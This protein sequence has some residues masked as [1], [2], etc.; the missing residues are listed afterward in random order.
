MT[1]DP[2]AGV[3][4]ALTI[5]QPWAALIA[6]GHKRYETRSYQPRIVAPGDRFAIHAGAATVDVAAMH[7]QQLVVAARLPLAQHF[8]AIIATARLVA[9][10]PTTGTGSPTIGRLE[11]YAGD[12][13][14]GRWAWELADV[15]QLDQ[16]IPCPGKLGLWRIR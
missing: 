15:E 8:G 14:R 10:H 5:R 1:V 11:R 16:P 2:L 7:L 6:T 3:E 13:S 9:V 12:W 4:R